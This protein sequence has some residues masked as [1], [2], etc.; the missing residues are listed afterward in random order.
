MRNFRRLPVAVAL[1]LCLCGALAVSACSNSE[2]RRQSQNVMRE[3][4]KAQR[5]YAR[6]S[7]MLDNAVFKVNGEVAPVRIELD[8]RGNPI[9]KRAG[10]VK[11]T[12]AEGPSRKAI[13]AID[14]AEAILKDALKNNPAADGATRALSQSMLAKVLVQKAY[15]RTITAD[16]AAASA[17]DAAHEAHRT[18]LVLREQANL[19]AFIDRL[20][21]LGNGDME[22]AISKAGQAVASLDKRIRARRQDVLRKKAD[23]DSFEKQAAALGDRARSFRQ[24]SD[25]ARG[26]KS[27]E[28]FDRAQGYEKRA[29]ALLFKVERIEQE[30]A[31]L[32]AE[33]GDLEM[34]R[35][36]AMQREKVARGLL[37]E[38]GAAARV[39]QVKRRTIAA[40][41]A[42]AKAGVQAFLAANAD[43][44]ENLA[45]AQSAALDD[46]AQAA[47]LLKKAA[48]S[49]R[50]TPAYIAAQAAALTAA[51]AVETSS[52]VMK[53]AND[54]LVEH[55]SALWRGMGWKLPAEL[56]RIRQYTADP[57]KVRKAAIAKYYEAAELYD[58]AAQRV[59][60]LYKWSY[61][62]LAAGAYYNVARLNKD[63][64]ALDKASSAVSAALDGQRSSPYLEGAVRLESLIKNLSD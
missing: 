30:T 53:Q 46:Y 50:K 55:A 43:A 3:L 64:D 63:S 61:Q 26:G 57:D 42:A 60:S 1:V 44:C 49:D 6:V 29:N 23:R 21:T 33:T 15:C 22:E 19:L 45:A 36:S 11:I 31:I 10:V 40:A 62:E 9:R 7:E 24:Q 27:L 32:Q 12:W 35:N 18:M 14:R 37:A 28:L 47:L 51:A 58:Q 38:R 34:E 2:P 56:V 54:L 25:L 52:L 20:L 5:L 59:D 41:Q 13:D 4:D 8:D 39:R 16:Q 17:N 48:M